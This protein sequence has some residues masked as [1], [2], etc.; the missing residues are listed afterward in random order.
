MPFLVLSPKEIIVFVWQG[1]S[2][3]DVPS[4]DAYNGPERAPPLQQ[5][6]SAKSAVP[7]PTHVLGIL[8]ELTQLIL[9][10]LL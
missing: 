1:L 6:G 10:A 2:C 5:W 3:E 8:Y 7:H 9:T 4:G